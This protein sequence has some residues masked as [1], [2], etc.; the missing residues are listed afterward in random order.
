MIDLKNTKLQYINNF[1]DMEIVYK[2]ILG[3]KW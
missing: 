2:Y 1:K 3:T